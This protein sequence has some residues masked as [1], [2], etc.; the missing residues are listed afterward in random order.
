MSL[1]SY[2]KV[3][4]S[5][6]RIVAIGLAVT[7]LLMVLSLVR[8]SPSGVALRSPRV[9]I[10]TSTLLL[11]QS[12]QV[13]GGGAAAF[14][15]GAMEYLAGI[16]AQLAGSNA[17]RRL[18]D[19]TLK[20][21]LEYGVA[22]EKDDS[23]NGLPLIDVSAF[24]TTPAAAAALANRVARALQNYIVANEASKKG[25]SRAAVSIVVR[26]LTS[27]ARLFQG[28]RLT[29]PLMLFVL[30]VAATIF[31]AFTRHNIQL[32]RRASPPVSETP[33]PIELEAGASELSPE[34][35]AVASSASSK[36]PPSSIHAHERG[37]PATLALRPSQRGEGG[38]RRGG[39][40]IPRRGVEGSSPT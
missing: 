7:L 17:V 1:L 29:G 20:Q 2:W 14:Q 10:A 34:P 23:G 35:T 30:G 37:K 31:A 27:D 12:D 32:G 36:P 11:E 3:L 15:P 16:Y 25:A 4:K 22:R 38:G 26:P 33:Q 9:Y 24:S 13:G 18:V 21:V 28:I 8:I 6:R 19:P 39:T 5:Q 40:S